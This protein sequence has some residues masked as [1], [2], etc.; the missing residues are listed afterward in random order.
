MIG[1][2][3][4]GPRCKIPRCM[5]CFFVAWILSSRPCDLLMLV[6]VF[7]VLSW[8][9]RGWI[10]DWRTTHADAITGF[11]R[12]GAHSLI[13]FDDRPGILRFGWQVLGFMDSCGKAQWQRWPRSVAYPV[14]TKGPDDPAIARRLQLLKA[15]RGTKGFF[16][17]IMSHVH[18]R[19]TKQKSARQARW[20]LGE[21][22]LRCIHALSHWM[23]WKILAVLNTISASPLFWEV[24]HC[25]IEMVLSNM[26]CQEAL[27]SYWLNWCGAWFLPCCLTNLD[28]T[29]VNLTQLFSAAPKP[30]KTAT[31]NSG[32]QHLEVVTQTLLP[33]PSTSENF[34]IP[35]VSHDVSM[36]GH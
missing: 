30:G 32:W 36:H 5:G 33:G 8:T 9:G 31:M 13:C 12:L 20:Y 34:W 6:D 17:A 24:A 11:W 16:W 35:I 18:A 1:S 19:Q 4:H 26:S 28:A 2:D 22:P 3:P 21:S 10:F 25:G 29:S 15:G 7:D 23:T 14:C 27:F